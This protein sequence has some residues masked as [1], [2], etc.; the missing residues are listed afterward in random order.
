M[1]G[2]F[3]PEGKQDMISPASELKPLNYL[4]YTHTEKERE[5]EKD[6]FND[7]HYC[8]QRMGN[9]KEK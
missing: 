4:L 3:R 8:F 6:S 9:L 7:T 5:G 2:T 1:K